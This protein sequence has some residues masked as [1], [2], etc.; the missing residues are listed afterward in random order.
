M[1]THCRSFTLATFRSLVF[2]CVSNFF[3]HR[4]Q[5][6]KIA[7]DC[8]AEQKT[9]ALLVARKTGEELP[10]VAGDLI[11]IGYE[12]PIP[13]YP[14][15]V[16]PARAGSDDP[17]TMAAPVSFQQVTAS[18]RFPGISAVVQEDRSCIDARTGH[19]QAMQCSARDR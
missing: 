13:G 18:T 9:A 12:S 8:L 14:D 1:P 16:G 15:F 3:G 19:R 11:D 2:E 6:A 4:W 10:N 5:Q 7:F 17:T